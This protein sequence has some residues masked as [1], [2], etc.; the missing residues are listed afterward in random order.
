[1]LNKSWVNNLIECLLLLSSGRSLDSLIHKGYGLLGFNLISFI[2]CLSWQ[3]SIISMKAI[4][5]IRKI[6]VKRCKLV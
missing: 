1:M 5:F 3:V 6:A 2:G 4:V